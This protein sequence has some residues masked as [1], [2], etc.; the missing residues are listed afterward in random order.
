MSITIKEVKQIKPDKKNEGFLPIYPKKNESNQPEKEEINFDS[1][2]FNINPFNKDTV[3]TKPENFTLNNNELLLKNEDKIKF[4]LNNI[5]NQQSLKSSFHTPISEKEIF[6]NQ[7]F[8][9]NINIINNNTQRN[10]SFNVLVNNNKKSFNNINFNLNSNNYNN[11]GTNINQNNQIPNNNINLYRNPHTDIFDYKQFNNLYNQININ[12]QFYNNNSP[13]IKYN[14]NNVIKQNNYFYNNNTYSNNQFDINN[15]NPS[16]NKQLSWVC[17]F[18]NNNN[19]GSKNLFLIL[20]FYKF[21]Q[22]LLKV[23]ENSQ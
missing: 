21:S 7:N 15:N 8:D 23:W 18:C 9:N 12:N 4:E 10:P 17:P 1:F 16:M 6:Q 14:N 13:Q 3:E 19:F 2:D 5:Q 20:I 11:I 22:V